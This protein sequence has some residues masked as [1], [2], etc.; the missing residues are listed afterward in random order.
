MFWKT[1]HEDLDGKI[2]RLES[3]VNSSSHW[4]GYDSF[5]IK[6]AIELCKEIQEDFKKNIRYPSKSQRDEA[7]QKFFDLRE[8]VY[9]IKREAAEHQSEKHYREID[10]HLND[11]YF[12]NWEDEIGDVLTLGL[13][14]TKKETMVWKGKQLREAGRLLKEHKHEMIAKHK[15]EIHERII[16]TREEHDK[17]WLRY[18]EYQEEKQELYEKKKKAWEEGQIRREQAKERIQANID[19]N[20]VSLRKAE[21]AL[22]RQKQRRSD[23]EDQISSAWSDSFRERA[24]GWLDECNYK[25]SDIEDSISRLE[26]WIQ[27]GEDKLNSFY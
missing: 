16:S 8:D 7:W 19:K 15:N 27:E 21:D 10:H 14:Q 17:F 2:N 11:A 25:I 3:T 5:K 24:E 18:R 23:L 20:R 9:R 4:F 22:E 13:M 26:S 12:Y 6:D 1:T